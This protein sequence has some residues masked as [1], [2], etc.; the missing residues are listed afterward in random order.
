MRELVC[1]ETGHSVHL[2]ETTGKI[3]GF[4]FGSE[5]GAQRIAGTIQRVIA[6]YGNPSGTDPDLTALRGIESAIVVAT[7]GEFVGDRAMRWRIDGDRLVPTL[8]T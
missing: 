7:L 5:D 4:N 8:V 6:M 1:G 2:D 3:I